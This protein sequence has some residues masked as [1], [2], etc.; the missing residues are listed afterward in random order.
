M[1]GVAV[2]M[3][4]PFSIV[5]LLVCSAVVSV[6]LPVEAE[7]F[8]C[9][10]EAGVVSLSNVDTKGGCKKMK[11][12]PKP[13]QAPSY[14]QDKNN[15]KQNQLSSKDVRSDH[16]THTPSASEAAAE[17]KRIVL[18]ELGLERRRLESVLSQVAAVGIRTDS[19]AE[20][21]KFLASAKKKESLHRSNIELLEKEFSRLE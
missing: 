16:A 11:L 8:L 9:Q 2:S 10:S 18:E 13:K 5:R 14:V 12:Q 6:S 21:Q 20:R 19:D 3:I 4:I 7:V 17:R 1:S 15:S